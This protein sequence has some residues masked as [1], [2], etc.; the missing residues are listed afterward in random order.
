MKKITINLWLFP[1]IG[2][3]FILTGCTISYK[4]NGASINYDLTKSISIDHFVNQAPLVYPPLEPR[5]NEH[6]KDKFTRN[7]RLEILTQGGDMEMEG[8]I[9]GYELTPLAVQEDAFA[10]ETRLTMTVRMRFRNN[11]QEGQDKEETFSANTTF[12]SQVMLTDIQDQLIDTLIEE[13]VDQMFNST[14]AN[15]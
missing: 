10:A 5:F 7:T 14:M 1:V 6:L 11:K 2:L 12:S 3:I 15:W 8:E 13:I 4:F 9:V